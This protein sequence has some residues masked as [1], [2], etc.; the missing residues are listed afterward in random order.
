M[1]E[2]LTTL[3]RWVVLVV[4]GWG[5][6][7]V[8]VVVSTQWAAAEYDEQRVI[9]NYRTYSL[10]VLPLRPHTAIV[11]IPLLTNDYDSPNVMSMVTISAPNDNDNSADADHCC[12]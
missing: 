6:G 7:V 11:Q 3:E 2:S 9:I 1:I 5:G 10:Q 4:G 12:H 8:L